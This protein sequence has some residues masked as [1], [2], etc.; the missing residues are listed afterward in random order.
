[1]AYEQNLSSNILNVLQQDYTDTK[2]IA[3]HKM[4]QEDARFLDNMC[5]N[6]KQRKDNYYSMPLS[7]KNAKLQLPNNR[8]I[9]VHRL[10]ILKTKMLKD[11]KYE[12]DYVAFM[13]DI[14]INGDA[15]LVPTNCEAS[16][17]QWYIP[18][19]GV[20]HPK[21]KKIGKA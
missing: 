15:E 20:Y 18:H 10:D 12:T 13:A 7:F 21:K 19:F 14:I 6:I 5:N 2:C 8:Q 1:M 9:A 11:Q 4:S 17:H 3:T 16:K